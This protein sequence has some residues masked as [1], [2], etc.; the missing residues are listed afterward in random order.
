MIEDATRAILTVHCWDWVDLVVG[1]S[2]KK[3]NSFWKLFVLMDG[4]PIVG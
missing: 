1:Y 3:G 4:D 2:R